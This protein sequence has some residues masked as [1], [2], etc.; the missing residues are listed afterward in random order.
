MRMPLSRR[1]TT[2]ARKP[3]RVPRWVWWT[4]AAATTLIAAVLANRSLGKPVLFLRWSALRFLVSRNWHIGDGRED[5][6]VDYVLTHARA[7]DLDD[8]IRVVDDFCYRRSFLMNVGDEKGV[9]LERAIRKAQPTRL[10]ELGAYC[11]YSALRCARAMPAEAQLYS[12]EFNAANAA[13]ARRI[14]QHAGIDDRV[15]AVVG[16]L[17]D[18]TTIPYLQA[19][20]GFAQAGVDFVFLD[21]DKDAY[22]ADLERVRQRGWLHAGAV[23]VADNIK[24]P[25]AP[26]YRAY[27]HQRDGQ[28]WRT[29]EHKTRAE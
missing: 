22:V 18:E 12:V 23:V 10:L 13:I 17:G 27:M 6:L 16:S 1:T 8:V 21:H 20:H 25:G 2:K 7:G 26:A 29:T 11:G 9:I 15:T 5:E 24:F 19:E 3:R 14:W 4:G 28:Q